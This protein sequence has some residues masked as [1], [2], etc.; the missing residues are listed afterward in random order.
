MVLQ[1]LTTEYLC[2][3]H[4][5]SII[6]LKCSCKCLEGCQLIR[7]FFGFIQLVSN[8]KIS[9]FLLSL[10][11]INHSVVKTTDLFAVIYHT[12]WC[13][14]G[15]SREIPCFSSTAYTDFLP[16]S[17]TGYFP[18]MAYTTITLT[19]SWQEVLLE[20]SKYSSKKFILLQEM[21]TYT[22]LPKLQAMQV[23]FP[24][25]FPSLCIL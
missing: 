14:Y 10:S 11:A 20:M 6:F 24:G 13:K 5:N 3:N 18:G 9:F 2:E 23:H 15:H 4:H 12:R 8:T 21:K 22:M 25:L 7:A 19:C 1:I 17:E 16:G